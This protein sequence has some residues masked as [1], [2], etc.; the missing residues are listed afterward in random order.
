[1]RTTTVDDPSA[2]HACAVPGSDEQLWEMTARFL[3]IGLAAGEQVVYLSDGTADAVLERLVDDRVP[4]DRPLADGQ[5]TIVDP[6]S[7]RA[8]MRVR[9]AT[10]RGRWPRWWTARSTPATP[11]CG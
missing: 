10:R 6:E 3:G 8:S 4:V 2:V 1:M 9:C 11:G 7:T 5:L